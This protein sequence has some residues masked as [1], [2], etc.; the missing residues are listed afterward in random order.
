MTGVLSVFDKNI[1]KSLILMYAGTCK[2]YI[3]KKVHLNIGDNWHKQTKC[4]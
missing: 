2:T 3:V 1:N 4:I